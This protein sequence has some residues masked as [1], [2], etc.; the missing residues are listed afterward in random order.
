MIGGN[1]LGRAIQEIPWVIN[2]YTQMT[3]GNCCRLLLPLLHEIPSYYTPLA[4]MR[5]EGFFSS[6]Q[7]TTMFVSMALPFVDVIFVDFPLLV[8][9][10]LMSLQLYVLFGVHFLILLATN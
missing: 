5:S 2:C 8:F 9:T 1:L 3:E 10:P 7:C 6:E 4:V